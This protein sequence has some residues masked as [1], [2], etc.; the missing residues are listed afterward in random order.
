MEV[1]EDLIWVYYYCYCLLIWKKCQRIWDINKRPHRQREVRD[2]NS[3]KKE[4]SDGVGPG[5]TL[6]RKDEPSSIAEKNKASWNGLKQMET[7]VQVW[8]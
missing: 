8:W 6:K 4:E 7:P 1:R 5:E 3:L 2:L